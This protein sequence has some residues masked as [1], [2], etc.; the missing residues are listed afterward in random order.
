MRL[1]ACFRFILESCMPGTVR[2]AYSQIDNLVLVLAKPNLEDLVVPSKKFFFQQEKDNYFT[3]DDDSIGNP[4]QL[5]KEWIVSADKDGPWKFVSPRPCSYAITLTHSDDKEQ[6][7]MSSL[8]NVS[9]QQVFN[10]CT[11]MLERQPV[12]FVQER[13]INRLLNTKTKHVS[14]HF[15]PKQQ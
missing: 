12:V 1:N 9:T 5:Q 14:I 2:C 11:R 8:S 6:C 10:A 15:V 7:K 3:S 4:G 13:R